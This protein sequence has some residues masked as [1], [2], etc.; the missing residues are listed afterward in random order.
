M[1]QRIKQ[2]FIIT[3][4][5]ILMAAFI[6]IVNEFVPFGSNT[7][8]TVDLGQQYIDFY[9][10]FRSTLL[11][12]PENFLYSFAKGI[13]GET[14]GLWS[15]YL[16]SPFNLILLFFNTENLHHGVS[17]LTLLKLIAMANTFYYYVS[18]TYRINFKATIFFTLSYTFM[19]YNLVYLLN[20]M[21]LDGLIWL[22]IITLGLER[23]IKHQGSK[24]YILSL[25]IMMM[26]NYY[27]AYMIA[28]FLVFFTFYL[29]IIH[30]NTPS[31]FKDNLKIYLKFVGASIISALIAGITLI[32][33]LSSLLISKGSEIHT[34]FS[35]QAVHQLPDIIAKLW[36]GAFDFQ[37]L[38]SSAPNIYT[39][40]LMIILVILY[41]MERCFPLKE[42]IFAGIIF[43]LY[44]ISFRYEFFDLIWHGGQFPI[45]YDYRF[46]FTLTFFLIFLSLRFYNTLESKID[47]RLGLSLMLILAAGIFYYLFQDQYEYLTTLNLFLSL[48]FILAYL[49]ILMNAAG[50][51]LHHLLLLLFVSLELFGN[52][53]MILSH[54]SYV[55][56]APFE[57]YTQNILAM[58][59]DLKPEEDEF[60]RIH[61]TFQRT[62]NE[63]F[64]ADYYGLDHFSSTLEDR[65]VNLF[66]YLGQPDGSGFATYTHGTLPLDDLLGIRYLIDLKD[67]ALEPT[68][69]DQYDYRRFA[70]DLDISQHFLKNE[71]ENTLLYENLQPIY[72]AFEVGSDLTDVK[73]YSHHPFYNQDTLLNLMDYN[74]E[75][76]VVYFQ[77]IEMG[78]PDY[79]QIDWTVLEGESYIQYD[80][81][82]LENDQNDSAY[83]SWNLSL[84]EDIH[85]YITIPSQY[86][87]SRVDIELAGKELIFYSPFRSRQTLPLGEYSEDVDL[88]LIIT[89]LEEQLTANQI[90]L[91][92]FDQSAYQ[93]LRQAYPNNQLELE[94]FSDTHITGNIQFDQEEGFLLFMLP[95]DPSWKV[96]VDG[97][98]V[99]TLSVLNDT[100]MAIPMEQGNHQFDMSYRPRSIIYGIVSTIVGLIAFIWLYRHKA[101]NH[102]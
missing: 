74:N 76:R 88:E 8:L 71:G 1:K 82:S 23:L 73:F 51:M 93:I 100:L 9:Q 6:S 11:E 20:I 92:S 36:I 17:L 41:F 101:T 35:W 64:Y 27:I 63:S 99:E 77:E 22:P 53:L 47:L 21:W 72:L 91:Y 81:L 13:G 40:L 29:I 45:W 89:M 90:K 12:S 33:T 57:D 32:P 7:L 96:N 55:Q 2:H 28:I 98:E 25:A 95:Y 46:S 80:N 31:T 70:S 68:S 54:F 52:S 83:F 102:S 60:Y 97:I 75:S 85:Y 24:L 16:M 38:S 34:D 48:L 58:T 49:L 79:H 30:Q 66:G 4:V 37:E 78:P 56:D 42:K 19:A 67:Q 69:K 94:S 61:K 14:T 5:V 59:Q 3:F 84:S 50:R 62:K 39:S 87:N 44:F 15:Y 86:S 65:T 43:I 18:S 10:L 26:S